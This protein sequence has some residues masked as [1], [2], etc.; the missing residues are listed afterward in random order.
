MILKQRSSKKQ[1]VVSKISVGL[2][3]HKEKWVVSIFEGKVHQRTYSQESDIDQLI[4][5]LRKNYPDAVIEMVYEAG[6][7]GFWIQRALQEA[8][9]KCL[10]VHAADIPSTD[11][12]RKRKSDAVDAR[13]LASLLSSGLLKGIYVPTKEQEQIRDLVRNRTDLSVDRRRYMCRI[14]SYLLRHGLKVPTTIKGKLWSQAGINWLKKLSQQHLGLGQLVLTYQ[15]MHQ[16]LLQA[17]RALRKQIKQ[18]SYA[19]RYND[20]MTIPGVGWCTASLLIAELGNIQR[21][22]GI[23]PLASYCGLVPDVRSSAGKTSVLG[24]SKRGNRKLRTALIESAWIAKR[25]DPDL[26]QTYQRAIEQGKCPQKAIVKVGRRLLNRIRAVWKK[27]QPYKKK[28]VLEQ[29][30][31]A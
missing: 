28:K 7:C 31:A 21:F 20:L 3:V 27:G 4:Q 8:G 22:K 24:L 14:R 13:R 23:D 2:D 26:N 10:I 16:R 29:A 9:M 19:Q 6:C 17:G 11:W 25:Y 30:L 5:H 18:S 1:K 12:E 15:M